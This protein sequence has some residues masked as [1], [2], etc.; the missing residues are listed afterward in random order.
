MQRHG[1][2]SFTDMGH[3]L[4]YAHEDDEYMEVQLLPI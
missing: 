4:M 3:T 1:Q 2:C